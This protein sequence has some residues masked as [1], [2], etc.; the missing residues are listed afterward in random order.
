[1]KHYNIIFYID[2]L[3]KIHLTISHIIKIIEEYFEEVERIVK[4][5]EKVNTDEVIGEKEII[6]SNKDSDEGILYK[7]DKKMFANNM[8][9]IYDNSDYIL[10][11]D[12]NQ[13]NMH[14]SVAIYSSFD[15][16]INNYDIFKTNILLEM[17]HI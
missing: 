9:V 10:T 1:M 12:T 8:S 7:N 17:R 13:S 3:T 16:F 14:D 5:N 11:V 6:V 4:C 2:G 15:N